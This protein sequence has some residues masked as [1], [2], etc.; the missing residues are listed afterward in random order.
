MKSHA[1]PSASAPSA[2]RSVVGSI[3]ERQTSTLK[4]HPQNAIIPT[5]GRREL[6]SFRAD[7]GERGVCVPLEINR[8]GVVLDGHLRLQ[9]ARE[10]GLAS[11]PVRVIAPND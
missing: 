4:Q 3:E 8:D 7:I 2:D 11:V 10:L 5:L 1:R 6:A 9:A